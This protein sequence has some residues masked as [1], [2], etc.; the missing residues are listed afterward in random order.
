VAVWFAIEETSPKVLLHQ[1]EK[2]KY[3]NNFYQPFCKD[4][5]MDSRNENCI[6]LAF[7]NTIDIFGSPKFVRECL[8]M[9]GYPFPKLLLFDEKHFQYT[10]NRPATRFHYLARITT[11]QL[12][13][14]ETRTEEMKL[15]PFL[16][17]IG[18]RVIDAK[19]PPP[20]AKLGQRQ[21]GAIVLFEDDYNVF[22][23]LLE[24]NGETLS[25][26]LEN[27]WP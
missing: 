23:Q 11:E 15:N 2:P 21:E 20:I 18:L 26:L 5:W 9:N 14:I 19:N 1:G 8:T 4:G 27:K 10:E 24:N 25:R 7:R 6:G 12:E 17:T 16:K 3:G 13:M 22:L